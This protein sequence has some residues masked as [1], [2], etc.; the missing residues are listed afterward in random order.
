MM[1]TFKWCKMSTVEYFSD[2]FKSTK[3]I[4]SSV[5]FFNRYSVLRKCFG[6]KYDTN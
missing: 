4:Y 1:C 3:G 5:H 2:Y 6:P